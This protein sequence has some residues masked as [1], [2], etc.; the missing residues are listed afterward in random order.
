MD[1]GTT[2]RTA[3]TELVRAGVI[4]R[5][6]T[7]PSLFL[8]GGGGISGLKSGTALQ[9]HGM[10]TGVCE[11]KVDDLNNNGA[12]HHPEDDKEKERDI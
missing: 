12:E 7:I 6:V 11:Q 5:L 4:L 9:F 2:D 1:F 8:V 3:A 10:A